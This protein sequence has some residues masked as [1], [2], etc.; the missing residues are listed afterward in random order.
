MRTISG[1]I[2]RIIFILIIGAAL[3]ISFNINMEFISNSLQFKVAIGETTLGELQKN[4]INFAL[5]TIL[6]ILLLILVVYTLLLIAK[7]KEGPNDYLNSIEFYEY[8]FEKFVSL[9]ADR[10]TFSLNMKDVLFYKRDE[11]SRSFVKISDG[12]SKHEVFIKPSEITNVSRDY[13]KAFN[14]ELEIKK[15]G[16]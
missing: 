5:V 1:L 11:G 14:C 10:E 8:E 16:E 2:R 4:T 12:R 15:V 9:E 13:L 3:I 7:I 6:G